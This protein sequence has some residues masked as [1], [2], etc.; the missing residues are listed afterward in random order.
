MDGT[1]TPFDGAI[2]DR[3]RPRAR[4][5]APTAIVAASLSA[6]TRTDADAFAGVTR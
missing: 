6:T 2:G 1:V 4:A 3:H 5:V